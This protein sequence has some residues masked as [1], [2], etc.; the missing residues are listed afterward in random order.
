MSE[1]NID[2]SGMR[3]PYIDPTK[4][5]PAPQPMTLLLVKNGTYTGVLPNG[6]AVA[7]TQLYQDTN[8]L[9]VKGNI[10]GYWNTFGHNFTTIGTRYLFDITNQNII[11]LSAYDSTKLIVKWP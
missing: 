4:V 7:Q 5:A 8:P 10:Y 9:N 3:E 6:L 11:D 2:L 1:P